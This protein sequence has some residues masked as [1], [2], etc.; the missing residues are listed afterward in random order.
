MS[1][2]VLPS[3]L[4][5]RWQAGSGETVEVLDA[6]TGEPVTRVGAAGLD[7]GSAVAQARTTGRNSLRELDFHA[8]AE[9]LGGVADALKQRREELYGW[10]ARAGCT[11]RDA[12]FD[13]DGGI[14]TTAYYAGLGRREL[15]AGTVILEDEP[16]RLGRGGT[17]AGR[18]LLTTPDGICLQINAFNFPVWG[19]L[20]KLAPAVLAGVPTIVKAATPTAYVA[21]HAV[22]IIV[23]S[24][25]LPPGVLQFVAGDVRGLLDT[26]GGQDR[27]A[28]TGSAAT[29]AVIRSHPA[30]TRHGVHVNVEA[31][32]LNACVLGPDAAPATA[33]F[34]LFVDTVVTELTLKTGQKCTAVRRALVPR[35]WAAAAADAIAARLAQ[36]VVG[37]PEAERVTMGPL[38]GRAQRDDVRAVAQRIAAVG[39]L[40][41]GDPGRVEPVGAD[42]DRGA[43]LAP[44]LIQV[45]DPGRPEPHEL[46]PFGP[47]TTLLP[48]RSPQELPALLARGGGAL[49][50]SIVSADHR[51]AAA[52][53]R[54][55]APWQG[56][57]LV[58]DAGCAGESTGHGTV[59]P[60]LIHGGPGRAGGGQELGGLRAVH[61]LMRRTAV[62]GSP[63]L[64]ATLADSSGHETT[65]DASR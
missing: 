6:A 38:V 2:E 64:L 45:D 51:F 4:A 58:L 1:S 30:V 63:D 5:G 53:V 3:Y 32:S 10:S 33:E 20:E 16:V 36:V 17:F 52:L 25:L 13:V 19:L 39:K 40:V 9:L 55:A 56:R 54:E 15:P 12:A 23:D 41:H 65:D 57:L 11:R 62:Q 44:L 60:Q 50:G 37:A 46:E 18:H 59:M 42:A 47:V 22:R 29:G 28:F 7:L 14:G 21:A 48:Y 35:E 49:V 8:R 43:F 27:I 61:G 26:L 24:G 34:G 31:D